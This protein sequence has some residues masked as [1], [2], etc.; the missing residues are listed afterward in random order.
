MSPIITLLRH[1]AQTFTPSSSTAPARHCEPNSFILPAEIQRASRR[2]GMLIASSADISLLNFLFPGTHFDLTFDHHERRHA[3]LQNTCFLRFLTKG[4]LHALQVHFWVANI[5]KIPPQ[6]RVTLFLDTFNA[7]SIRASFLPLPIPQP[8][9]K[10]NGLVASF[11]NFT[12]PPYI[13]ERRNPLFLIRS[14]C[15]TL[16]PFHFYSGSE[17]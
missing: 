8:F 3:F 14:Q 11:C 1:T 13:H 5:F 9:Q 7:Y 16:P 12:R 10:R 2:S 15:A 17:I 6:K 4:C